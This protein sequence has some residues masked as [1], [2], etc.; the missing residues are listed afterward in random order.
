MCS[1]LS[2][3]IARLGAG[4]SA[5]AG[6][7]SQSGWPGIGGTVVLYSHSWAKRLRSRRETRSASSMNSSV[8][9]DSPSY[10]CAQRYSS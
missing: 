2:I 4:A 10:C 6:S 7:S 5:A 8:P 3:S 9:T 1:L